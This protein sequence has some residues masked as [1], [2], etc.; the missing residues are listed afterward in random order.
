M[1]EITE[2]A[3]ITKAIKRNPSNG[4]SRNSIKAMVRGASLTLPESYGHQYVAT[5]L[6]IALGWIYD[7]DD[8]EFLVAELPSYNE[9]GGRIFMVQS[10]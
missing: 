6:A 3:I 7:E 4:L 1:S 10:K 5:K 9:D 8:I 2:T